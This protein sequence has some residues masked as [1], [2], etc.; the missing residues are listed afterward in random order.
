MKE[1]AIKRQMKILFGQ[2][3]ARKI[4]KTVNLFV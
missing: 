3:F 4:K 1:I 2:K